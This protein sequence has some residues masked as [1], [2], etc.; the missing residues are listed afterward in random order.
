MSVPIGGP[1][2]SIASGAVGAGT[3]ARVGSFICAF[4]WSGSLIVKT[5]SGPRARLPRTVRIVEKR[6]LRI[7]GDNLTPPVKSLEHDHSQPVLRRNSVLTQYRGAH[8]DSPLKLTSVCLALGTCRQFPNN[9]R[10][11]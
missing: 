3:L 11:K 7:C 2:M 9:R 6:I 8:Y 5:M 4:G 10:T 1:A